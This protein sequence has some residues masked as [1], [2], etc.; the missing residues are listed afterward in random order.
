MDTQSRRARR[1]SSGSGRTSPL[2]VPRA[3]PR[4]WGHNRPFAGTEF[5]PNPVVNAI[6]SQYV[7]S[8]KSFRLPV[9]F[10][11]LPMLPG[12][13]GVG[14]P[15]WV[16]IKGKLTLQPWGGIVPNLSLARRAAGG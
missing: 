2:G 4:L 3:H 16:P 15:V 13:Y 7:A 14:G 12:Y 10:G 9:T 11:R 1:G 8:Q 5:V 6:I